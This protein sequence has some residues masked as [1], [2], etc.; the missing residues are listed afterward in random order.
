M[1]PTIPAEQIPPYAQGG[2]PRRRPLPAASSQRQNNQSPHQRQGDRAAGDDPTALVLPQYVR[3]KD[4]RQ[5][6]I[7]TSW[8][9]VLRMIGDEGFPPGVRLSAN[10]RA[11]RLDEV[12]GWLA[13][14]PTERKEVLA[15]H[16][17]R[18]RGRTKST[19]KTSK[20]ASDAA[21]R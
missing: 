7:V 2:E 9:Q 10:I 14:R 17:G 5:A 8:P 21:E 11:W 15:L 4:L 6:G 1:P 18:R 3:F 16:P 13:G 12:Q 19:N 20:T